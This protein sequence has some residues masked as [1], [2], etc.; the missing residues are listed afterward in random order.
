[1]LLSFAFFSVAFWLQEAALVLKVLALLIF[2][3]L[4][5]ACPGHVVMLLPAFVQRDE[6]PA[7]KVPPL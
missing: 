2:V 6:E 5:L 4:V 3:L 7:A 1:M